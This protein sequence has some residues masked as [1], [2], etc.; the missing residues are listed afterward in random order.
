MSE[1]VNP[2]LSGIP[3]TLLIPLYCRAVESRRPDA[4]VKDERA[5]EL[6]GRIDYDFSQIRL[7]SADMLFTVMRVREFGRRTHD[8]L[9]AHPNAVVVSIGCGQ[10]TRFGRVAERNG[11]VEWYDLDLPHVIELRRK[12]I[13]GEGARYHLL[14]CSVLDPAWMDLLGENAKRPCL[15]LVEGVF[16]YFREA[17]VRQVVLGLQER[18]PGAELVFDALAPLVVWLHSRHP[19]A[20]KLHTRFWGLK[21][22]QELETWSPGIRLLSDWS[23]FDR[24]EP[25]LGSARLL[26]FVPLLGRG[27]SVVHYRLDKPA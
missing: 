18:F 5:V 3:E 25:R 11:T 26:R 14:G 23:Y 9:A 6:M 21:R 19:V 12:L 10:D 17:E 13:G 2:N 20:R 24:P 7:S 27:G 4:L 16:T 22:G 1:I 15:F 8:L